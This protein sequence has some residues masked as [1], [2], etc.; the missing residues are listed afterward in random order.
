MRRRQLKRRAGRPTGHRGGSNYWREEQFGGSCCCCRCS[1]HGIA[2]GPAHRSTAHINTIIGRRRC[3]TQRAQRLMEPAARTAGLTHT[4]SV[5]EVRMMV[6]LAAMVDALV[7][8][9]RVQSA[10]DLVAQIA[11]GVVQRL[12]MLLFL[13]ALKRELG[14]Q[15]LAA[16][17]APMAGIQRQGQEQPI[18]LGHILGAYR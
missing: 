3:G 16:D 9:Q 5:M 11:H 13:V 6:L 15:Q 1:G 14:A 17:V 8:V 12:Q 10:E 7:V 18:G 4:G 2:T